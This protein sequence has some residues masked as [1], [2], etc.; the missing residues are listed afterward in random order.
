MDLLQAPYAHRVAPPRYN[1]LDRCARAAH[2]SDARNAVSY[3]IFANR[4]FITEGVR[5]AGGGVN[6]EVDRTSLEKIDCIG[7]AFVHLE[8]GFRGHPRRANSF[9]GSTRRGHFKTQLVK[10]LGQRDGL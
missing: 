3:C 1:R 6:D 8:N 7:T 5:P 4:L 2:S 9:G 10:A